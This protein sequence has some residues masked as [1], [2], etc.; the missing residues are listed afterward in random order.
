M[1]NNNKNLNKF[2]DQLD[3]ILKLK[4][5]GIDT[6]HQVLQPIEINNV[7]NTETGEILS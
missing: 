5:C 1:H 6:L 4:L 3:I 7:M 2:L